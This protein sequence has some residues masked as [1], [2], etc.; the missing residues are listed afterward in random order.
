MSL[1]WR[2]L[3]ARTQR[4]ALRWPSLGAMVATAKGARFPSTGGNACPSA[5][6]ERR[7]A[8]PGCRLMGDVVV[9]RSKRHRQE[10]A[11]PLAA[12]RAGRG[13]P[14][15]QR[16][17]GNASRTRVEGTLLGPKLGCAPSHLLG[18]GHANS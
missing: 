1:P 11:L 15:T 2:G 17:Q 18:R 16:T 14:R 13:G 12:D 5:T 6:P 10:L 8:S 3:D 7:T 9:L 4:T